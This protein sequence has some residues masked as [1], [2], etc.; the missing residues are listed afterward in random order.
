MFNE[1]YML[2]IYYISK[3]NQLFIYEN[4]NSDKCLDSTHVNVK[5]KEIFDKINIKM[6][7]PK[8]KLHDLH[9]N[10]LTKR[11]AQSPLDIRV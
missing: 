3:K 10:S 4:L 2:A 1:G 11:V 9:N 7:L 5:D 6:T 8:S